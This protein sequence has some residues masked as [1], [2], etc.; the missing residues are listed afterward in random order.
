MPK[1]Y[2]LNKTAIYHYIFNLLNLIIKCSH[3]HKFRET[4]ARHILQISK[5]SNFC[6]HCSIYILLIISLFPFNKIQIL[7]LTFLHI[8]LKHNYSKFQ[9]MFII[10]MIFENIFIDFREKDIETSMTYGSSASY[11]LPN[12]IKPITLSMCPDMKSNWRPWGV[13]DDT[14]LTEPQQP[15]HQQNFVCV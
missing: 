14:Q 8:L 5:L 6:Q 2:L 12:G 13:W 3:M 1:T 7:T 10:N 15:G 9:D 4:N 11:M